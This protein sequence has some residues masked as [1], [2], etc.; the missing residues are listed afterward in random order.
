[1]KSVPILA[2]G[3]MLLGAS[4]AQAAQTMSPAA[5]GTGP[6]QRGAVDQPTQNFGAT[7]GTPGAID[8][9]RGAKLWRAAGVPRIAD[10]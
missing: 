1:M 2:A 6:G 3:A 7:P 10:I 5:A 8:R 9:P 4:A